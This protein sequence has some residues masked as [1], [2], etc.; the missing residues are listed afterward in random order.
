MPRDLLLEQSEVRSDS[1][2]LVVVRVGPGPI[3]PGVHPHGDKAC[4]I[5]VG[6]R[7]RH[8]GPET[9]DAV[10]SKRRQLLIGAIKRE[11]Q[12]QIEVL[13]RHL[14]TARHHSDNLACLRI[15]LNRAPDDRPVTAEAALPVAIA[16]HHGPRPAR[17]LIGP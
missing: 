12:Q 14:K 15:H 10:V 11:G 1:P 2:H 17:I 8:L 6:L 16:E 3:R 9:C 4:D 7:K 5:G 13:I